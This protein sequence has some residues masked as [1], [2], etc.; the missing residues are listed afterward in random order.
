MEKT[1]VLIK[2]DA[3]FRGLAGQI[4]LR[5]EN[6]GLKIVGLKMINLSDTLLDDH[7][8]HLKD[9]PF[10][11]KIKG[12]MKSAP[13]LAM[14]IEGKDC[15]NVVRKMCGVTN[16]RVAEPGT[17]R[18]DF[19]MSMQCNLVHASDSLETASVEVK[20]FFKPEELFEYNLSNMNFIYSDDEVN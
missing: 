20:R 17:I 15:V 9:K 10:F 7:Y 5:F 11:P 1:L 14:C 12:F 16:S 4:I 19:G 8:S 18:G 13:V 2:P 6:K 3:I